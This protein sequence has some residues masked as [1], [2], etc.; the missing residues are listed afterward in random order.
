MKN[1]LGLLVCCLLVGR[2]ARAQEAGQDPRVGEAK[3]ACVAGD[4]QTGVR[5]LAELY[6]ASNDPIWIFNQGRCYHQNA[7]P[8]LALSR[9][10]EFLRKSQGAL[11]ED[12]RDAQKYIAEIEADQQRE[13]PAT[14]ATSTATTTAPVAVVQTQTVPPEPG[15]GLRQTGIGVGI[16]GGA[17]LATGIVFTLLVKQTASDVENQ[18]KNDVV[19]ASVVSGK[20]ADGRRYE[21]LQW[22]S[23]GVGAAA[24]VAGSVL[25]WMGAR[26]TSA[27][28]RVSSTCLF[29]VLMANGAGAG[30]HM[31]F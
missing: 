27:E 8:A 23:Y 13:Q 28:P 25:Y 12:I 3:A 4:V 10:K 29:P 11:A 19:P 20:L 17:A 1:T 5:L 26:S 14:A 7:Q 31:A 2:V 30:L 15:R 22:V 18:T 6:L 21:T 9:F 16:F 24:V